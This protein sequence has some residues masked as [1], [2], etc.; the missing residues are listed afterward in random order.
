MMK[1]FKAIYLTCFSILCASSANA[2]EICGQL[3]Q[4]ELIKGQAEGAEQVFIDDKQVEITSD[5]EFLIAFDRD[6]EKAKTLQIARSENI[7]AYPLEIAPTTWDVQKINGVP[8]RKVEPTEKDLHKINIEREDLHRALSYHTTTPLWQKGF[9]MPVKGRISGNFGGQRIMNK[10]P[11]SPHR[12]I[13][14]AA[15]ENTPVYASSDGTVTLSGGDYFYIGNV[16][17]L[18]HGQNLSTIYAHLKNTTVKKGDKVKQGDIIGY[19]G[20]TGRATGP[21]LHWGASINNV[22]FQPLSLLKLG[23]KTFCS[24]L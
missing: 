13:D 12:G 19:V 18:D 21:H 11:R 7:D 3:A 17:V 6:A 20:K 15:P 4:G 2:V 8:P 1:H 22:R 9:V 16:V 10:K 14:I 24:N 5:G 23:D